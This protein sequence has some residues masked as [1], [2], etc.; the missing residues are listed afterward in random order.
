[1]SAM[2]P[3]RTDWVPR[4]WAKVQ[5]A[6][7]DGC[8]LWTGYVSGNGYGRFRKNHAD[9]SQAAHR[10]T[11][12]LEVGPIPEG[13][14]LDHLCRVRA[15]VRPSHLEP[16]TRSENLARG[17]AGGWQR[18]KDRC[19]NGHPFTEENT[20]RRKDRPNRRECRTCRR[21]ARRRFVSRAASNG[22]FSRLS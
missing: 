5:R 9:P 6:D 7:G 19:D 17:D 22:E 21:D 13:H 3:P 8:W 18:N 16:V 2:P 10:L 14:D 15:C 1:M 12:E 11:Y 4:L 20:Y